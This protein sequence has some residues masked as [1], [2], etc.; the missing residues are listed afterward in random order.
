L[1]RRRYPSSRLTKHGALWK[2][3]PPSARSSSPSP[4]S[5]DSPSRT[6]PTMTPATGSSRGGRAEP[7]KLWISS[8]TLTAGSRWHVSAHATRCCRNYSPGRGERY[9]CF[10]RRDAQ[11]VSCWHACKVRQWSACATPLKRGCPPGESPTGTERL[12]RMGLAKGLFMAIWAD[13]QFTLKHMMGIASLNP[14]YETRSLG[15]GSQ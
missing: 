5:A 10:R 7:V 15:D 11:S 1:S 6:T 2:T 13:C 9:P 3:R 12:C 8:L 14:S 4:T